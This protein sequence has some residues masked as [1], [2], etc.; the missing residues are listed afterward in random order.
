M[1]RVPDPDDFPYDPDHG[2][3]FEPPDDPGWYEDWSPLEHEL[4]VSQGIENDPED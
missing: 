3:D 2:T 4:R 1:I